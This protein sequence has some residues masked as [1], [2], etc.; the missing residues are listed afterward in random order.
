LQD[1]PFRADASICVI[2]GEKLVL[3]MHGYRLEDIK[4]GNSRQQNK[5]YNTAYAPCAEDLHEL[6]E[7]YPLSE[8]VT[9]REGNG[10][11]I[12]MDTPH[13]AVNTSRC[14]SWNGT[15]CRTYESLLFAVRLTLTGDSRVDREFG[16]GFASCVGQMVDF[17]I[18]KCVV[19]R[20]MRLQSGTD[21]DIYRSTLGDVH[22]MRDIVG[23]MVGVG[24]NEEWRSALTLKVTL[25]LSAPEKMHVEYA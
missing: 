18:H 7:A 12:P 25:F 20:V 23:L 13:L 10:V 1:L 14:V 22:E 5:V 8:L 9:L 4:F 6:L 15:R 19:A 11:I 3:V 17:A 21:Y 24:T 2:E 16:C